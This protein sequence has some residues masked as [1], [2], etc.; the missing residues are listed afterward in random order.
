MSKSLQQLSKFTPSVA[1]FIA[2]QRM[3]CPHR[4]DKEYL[5]ISSV[6]ISAAKEKFAADGAMVD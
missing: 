4:F 6:Q 3:V 1:Q 5:T 2:A